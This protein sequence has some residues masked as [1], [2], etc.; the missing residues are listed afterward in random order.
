MHEHF[1]N[2]LKKNKVNLSP[3]QVLYQPLEE[4][5]RLFTS[6]TANYILTSGVTSNIIK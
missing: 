2:H 3:L 5:F 4:Y 1:T 6:S